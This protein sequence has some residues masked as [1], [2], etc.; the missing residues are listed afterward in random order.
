M[1]ANRV[2]RLYISEVEPSEELKMLAN[3][4]M[5][6]YVTVWFGIK[7]HPPVKLGRVDFFKVVQTTRQVPEDV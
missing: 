1:C 6:K 4:I 3:Y 7:L 2:L 5:K